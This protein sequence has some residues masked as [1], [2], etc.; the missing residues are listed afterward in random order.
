M[1]EPYVGADNVICTGVC[2]RMAAY[3]DATSSTGHKL[4]ITKGAG[5]A[6]MYYKKRSCLSSI[7]RGYNPK[8]RIKQCTSGANHA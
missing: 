1:I 7:Y 4:F 8:R 6:C 3:D 5:T 2:E